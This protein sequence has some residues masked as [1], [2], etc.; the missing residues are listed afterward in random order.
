MVLVPIEVLEGQTIP[1]TL[2]EFLAPADVIVL[3][4]HVFPEQ[5]P[6]EQASLQFEDRAREAV[7]DIAQTFVDAGGDPETRVV[8]THDRE[9]T[10][11]RVAAAVGAPAILLPNPVGEISEV[12]VPILGALDGGEAAEE[13]AEELVGRD[14]NP[15]TTADVV[16]GALFVALERGLVV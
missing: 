8:F 1:D 12:L 4:Y 11:D 15:G 14:I 5:T 7:D 2:V 16:A 6:T 3:G 13:L 10:I 9:Q